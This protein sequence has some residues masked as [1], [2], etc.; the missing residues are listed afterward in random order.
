ML[1]V[2]LKVIAVGPCGVPPAKCWVASVR[3]TEDL[4]MT[5]KS[6]TPRL[7]SASAGHPKK[8]SHPPSLAH[9]AKS[10]TEIPFSVLRSSELFFRNPNRR[11]CRSSPCVPRDPCRRVTCRKRLDRCLFDNVEFL[12]RTFPIG[13]RLLLVQ[14]VGDFSI[15]LHYRFSISP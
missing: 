12:F 5:R 8:R 15:A 3:S 6:K 10:N 1:D 14:G 11:R 9:P 13:H 4:N 7:K 2:P